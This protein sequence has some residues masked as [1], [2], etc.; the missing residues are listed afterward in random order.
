MDDLKLRSDY[1]KAALMLSADWSKNSMDALF[2]HAVSRDAT[3]D[4]QDPESDFFLLAGALFKTERIK[5]IVING[6]KGERYGKNIPGESWEGAISWQKKLESVGIPASAII[7]SKGAY[8][9]KEENI[10][11][12]AVAQKNN[13]KTAAVLTVNYHFPRVFMGY[14]QTMKETG[15]WMLLYA[16]SLRGVNWFAPM[17]GSQGISKTSAYD[18]I[19]DELAPSRFPVYTKKGDLCSF[20]ELFDYLRTRK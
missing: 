9:T 11:F 6:S 7:H 19:E 18:L 8:N 14:I 17:T 1:G 15:Y 5:V 4:K 12:L 10:N 2:L 3:G 13:W 20:E 16:F